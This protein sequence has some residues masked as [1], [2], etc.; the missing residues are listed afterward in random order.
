MDLAN[1]HRTHEVKAKMVELNIKS[2]FNVGY[3]F[4]YNPCERMWA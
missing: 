3:S 2:V 4:K 1:Y